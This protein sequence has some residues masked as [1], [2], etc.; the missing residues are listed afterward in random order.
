[1]FLKLWQFD[2]ADM[3]TCLEVLVLEVL[4]L[5][6]SFSE[7]GQTFGPQ[8]WLRLPIGAHFSARLATNDCLVWIKEGHF[9]TSNPSPPSDWIQAVARTRH[10]KNAPLTRGLSRSKN[11][12]TDSDSLF[13]AAVLLPLTSRLVLMRRCLLLIRAA[14]TAGRGLLL[15]GTLVLLRRR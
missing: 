10:T 11:G 4:V 2:L 3:R 9:V 12:S 1:M 15:P 13:V 6:G 8:S 7:G 14:L 5:D